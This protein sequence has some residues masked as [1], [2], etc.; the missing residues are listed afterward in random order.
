MARKSW[1]K[2]K[3]VCEALK[4][5]PLPIPGLDLF[6]MAEKAEEFRRGRADLRKDKWDDVVHVL[7]ATGEVAGSVRAGIRRNRKDRVGKAIVIMDASGKTVGQV[8]H[9]LLISSEDLKGRPLKGTLVVMDET[10][11]VAGAITE[12][13]LNRSGMVLSKTRNGA[14]VVKKQAEH[15]SGADEAK[16]KKEYYLRLAYFFGPLWALVLLFASYFV[17]LP[18][19]DALKM[20]VGQL[21]YLFA[22]PGFD[23]NTLILGANSF[24][25]NP[26]LMAFLVG[27]QDAIVGVFL[28]MNFDHVKK[29]PILGKIIGDLEEDGS[30]MLKKYKWLDRLSLVGLFIPYWVRYPAC[31]KRQRLFPSSVED[32]IFHQEFVAA[33]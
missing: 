30:K 31:W 8:A 5:S 1:R 2:N 13:A 3:Q 25:L 19:D 23:P 24:G 9:D 6:L 10:G 4:E 22:I 32:T 18:T 28:C 7:D 29:I 11:K 33:Q 26:F 27:V 21:G 17:F 20:F 15:I 16:T 12:E 14:V